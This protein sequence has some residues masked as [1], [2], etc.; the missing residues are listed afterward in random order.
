MVR[1]GFRLAVL[2][3]LFTFASL[4]NSALSW[5]LPLPDLIP[6]TEPAPQCVLPGTVPKSTPP[7]AAVTAYGD[8]AA[9]GQPAG[10]G[11]VIPDLPSAMGKVQGQLIHKLDG[12]PPSQA[13]IQG[14]ARAV[15]SGAARWFTS[16]RAAANGKDDPAQ[17]TAYQDRQRAAFL[18]Q[19]VTSCNPCQPD[20]DGT[21]DPYN[22]AKLGLR[23]EDLARAAATA[24]GFTGTHLEEAVAIARAESGFDPIAANPT[25]NAR[26]MWQIMLTAHQDDP[27]I[28]KWRDPYANARMAYRISSRGTNWAPWSTW[29]D[30]RGK[31][32]TVQP[33]ADG[34]QCASFTGGYRTGAGKPW[35]GYSNGRIPPSALAHPQSAP[36]H[37]LRP[38]AAAAFDHLNAAYRARFGHPLGV[39]DSYRS[40]AAQVDVK[41]R[42]PGLAAAPGTSDHGWG[43]ALDVVVG[44]YG[45]TDYLWLRANA[46]RF[47]WDNPPWAR[48]GG[49]KREP[50]HWE[51][52]PTGGAA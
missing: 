22:Q 41:A 4:A 50:W 24:A 18:A 8:P 5:H 44:G 27:E 15:G 45:S 38:D 42:K 11:A 21:P 40:Y 26:G 39:T 46:P 3:F 2:A 37:L 47:G 9:T 34:M 30:V 1:A 14:V 25:S 43:L 7:G 28:G 6:N 49:S 29:A 51:W 32:G 31:V 35:G 10:F 48:P 19:N 52:Q 33:V 23:G 17:V 16:L 12:P 20:A 13:Q 36:R